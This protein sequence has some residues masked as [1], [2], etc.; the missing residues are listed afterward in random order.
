MLPRR[1]DIA[2][3]IAAVYVPRQQS[4]S[5][6]TRVSYAYHVTYYVKAI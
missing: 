3:N 6:A 5:A 1:H 2:A 4:M